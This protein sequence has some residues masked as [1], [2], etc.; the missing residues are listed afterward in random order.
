M[1]P[2]F[3]GDP[4]VRAQEKVG[5]RHIQDHARALSG[6]CLPERFRSSGLQ[7]CEVHVCR[8]KPTTPLLVVTSVANGPSIFF[9]IQLGPA[10]RGIKS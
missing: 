10:Y 3:L 2:S 9:C 7:I 4:L 5:Q 8:F 6:D 1:A